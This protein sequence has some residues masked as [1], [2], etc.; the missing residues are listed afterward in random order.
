MDE[1][2]V[3]Q[4]RSRNTYQNGKVEFVDGLS[5]EELM[6]YLKSGEDSVMFYTPV[7]LEIGFNYDGGGVT[8]TLKTNTV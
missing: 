2:L 5:D 3:W 6:E 8:V 4:F 7:G 1:E